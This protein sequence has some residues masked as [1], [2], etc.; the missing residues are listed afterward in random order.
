MRVHIL[1]CCRKRARLYWCRIS[2]RAVF[3][4]LAMLLTVVWRVLS[5]AQSYPYSTVEGGVWFVL[6][7]AQSR[8]SILCVG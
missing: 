3:L 5:R 4:K 1:E 6:G 2:F 8:S 7:F